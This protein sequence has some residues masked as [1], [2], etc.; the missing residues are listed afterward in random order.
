MRR[1][2]LNQYRYAGLVVAGVVLGLTLAS[3]STT[4]RSSPPTAQ[5]RPTMFPIASVS[6][7]VDAQ[8]SSG[9]AA[10]GQKLFGTLGCAACHTV[11]GKGGTAGPDLSQE[12]K[13]GRS[14]SWLA[15]Q[16]RNP[17]AHTPQTVMPAYGNLSEQQVSDLVD[18]LLSLSAAGAAVAPTLPGRPP[19]TTV[20]SSEVATGGKRWSQRC[21]QCHNL[22]PPAEYDD[23][24]W[25]VAVHHMR[26]RVPLT[27][28]EQRDILAFLQA[29]N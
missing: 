3:C 10:A 27:G 15:A 25:A 21:G 22:R 4:E 26:V 6:E 12:A 20:S 14:A 19:A 11:N 24:Q 23:A 16:I 9:G 5:S 17:K 1:T 18:Y 13:K 28:A 8:T 2:D 29:S 7:T